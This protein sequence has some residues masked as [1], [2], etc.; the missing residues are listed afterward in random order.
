MEARPLRKRAW[1]SLTSATQAQLESAQLG[2]RGD[3]Q[4]AYASYESSVASA[5]AA[6]KATALAE[7]NQSLAQSRYAAG[8]GSAIEI[9][10]AALSL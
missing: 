7:T 4:I 8:V 9:S 10:D 1:P 3:V 5:D 2:V 6:Q